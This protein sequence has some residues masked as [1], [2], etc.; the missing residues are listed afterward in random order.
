MNL[1]QFASSVLQGLSIAA[2]AIVFGM[3]FVYTIAYAITKGVV[4]GLN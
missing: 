4:A 3:S 2:A 1:K